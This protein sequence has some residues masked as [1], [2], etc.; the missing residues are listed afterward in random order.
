M[1]RRRRRRRRRGGS[2]KKIVGRR[3]RAQVHVRVCASIV[4]VLRACREAGVGL[5]LTAAQAHALMES[6]EHIGK[7]ML[8]VRPD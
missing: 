6:S 5:P 4:R 2:F 3:T 1:R 8:A 7:I